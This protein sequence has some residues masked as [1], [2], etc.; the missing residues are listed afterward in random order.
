M[1]VLNELCKPAIGNYETYV[2]AVVLGNLLHKSNAGQYLHLRKK[3]NPVVKTI[4]FIQKEMKPKFSAARDEKGMPVYD[5]TLDEGVGRLKR[6]EWKYKF[7]FSESRK[8]KILEEER[9]LCRQLITNSFFNY[10][11]IGSM[12]VEKNEG[13]KRPTF[14]LE[15]YFKS[16]NNGLKYFQTL[17]EDGAKA[18]EYIKDKIKVLLDSHSDKFLKI[19]SY[20]EKLKEC[21]PYEGFDIY[22]TGKWKIIIF[23]G[24]G[25]EII[26]RELTILCL[27]RKKPNSFYPYEFMFICIDLEMECG[28]ANVEEAKV[29]LRTSFDL[30]FMNMFENYDSA[31]AII[32]AFEEEMLRK[33][34]WKDAF[35]ELFRIGREKKVEKINEYYQYP[36]VSNA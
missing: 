26:S 19:E 4:F 15:N 6:I 25:K 10:I 20:S 13:L 27:Q 24:A 5:T 14:F 18:D 8:E 23:D 28:G 2:K 32:Q 29:N 3:H 16:V 31:N 17:V 11:S 9:M 33:T 12:L 30:L 36:G 1:C 35:K 21:K 7:S 34:I 22:T